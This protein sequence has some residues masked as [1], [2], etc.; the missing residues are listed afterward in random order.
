MTSKVTNNYQQVSSLVF[1]DGALADLQAILSWFDPSVAAIVLDP[2]Q[3]GIQQRADALAGM[4]GLDAVHIIS[5]GGSGQINLG[6][7]QLTLDTIARY[8]NQLATIGQAL[9]AT[10]DLLLYGCNVAQGSQGQAFIS[11][12][13]NATGADVAASLDLTGNT[14]LGGNWQLEAATGV[15]ETNALNANIAG[16]LAIISGRLIPCVQSVNCGWVGFAVCY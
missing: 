6:T 16:V 13:A 15:I 10:G 7:T 11:A 2:S 12:L 14:L 4:N 3:D 9:S 5:H 8:Q 1:I